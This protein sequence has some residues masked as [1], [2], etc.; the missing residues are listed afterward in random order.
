MII[1]YGLSPGIPCIRSTHVQAVVS[2]RSSMIVFARLRILDL[3]RVD[4]DRRGGESVS[5]FS[6]SLTASD[7]LRASSACFCKLARRAIF[8]GEPLVSD[9]RM[10]CTLGSILFAEAEWTAAAAA[11]SDDWINGEARAPDVL[12]DIRLVVEETED[13]RLP[14]QDVSG[15]EE[16]GADGFRGGIGGARATIVGPE[17]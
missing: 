1:A 15:C 4:A 17:T 9:W 7:T 6:D 10:T 12:C 13:T 8:E 11:D 3:D 5:S 14:R 2:G 16:G